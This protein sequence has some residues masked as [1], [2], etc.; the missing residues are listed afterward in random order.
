MFP[1]C[2]YL[3]FQLGGRKVSKHGG[4]WIHT[5]WAAE[6]FVL[7]KVRFPGAKNSPP[8]KKS[9]QP[10][11]SMMRW[12]TVMITFGHGPLKDCISLCPPTWQ[13][14]VSSSWNRCPMKCSTSGGFQPDLA[15]R[16]PTRSEP[17]KN[18]CPKVYEAA[19][20]NS[21]Q[22]T[23]RKLN[24]TLGY[25]NYLGFQRWVLEGSFSTFRGVLTWRFGSCYAH[26]YI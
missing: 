9:N 10:H 7:H 8:S 24:V 5:L 1:L 6:P 18:A 21:N 25:L 23:Y 16:V 4:W 19:S 12:S 17:C 11:Q 20:F 2:R 3:F 13:Q 26:T 14:G 22:V 15:G